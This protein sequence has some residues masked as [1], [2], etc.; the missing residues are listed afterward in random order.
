MVPP[1]RTASHGGVQGGEAVEAGLL[2]HRLRDRVGQQAGH[3]LH[4]LRAAGAVGLHADGVDDGVGA[5]ATG[6]LADDVAHAADVLG[7]VEVERL[8]AE[9][10]DAGEPLRHAV[11]GR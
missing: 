3:L 8:G 10:L 7:V 4:D 1:R 6:G 2:H 11:D 9:R 5:S